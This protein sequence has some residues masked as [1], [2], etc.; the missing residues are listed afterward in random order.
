MIH[1][2]LESTINKIILAIISKVLLLTGL[3]QA[4]K[5]M[6][7]DTIICLTDKI[8]PL[9]EKANAISIWNI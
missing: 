2:T 3:R 5:K 6:G 8:L 1:R 9:T 7:Y 4:G